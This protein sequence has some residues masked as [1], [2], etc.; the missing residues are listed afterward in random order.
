[1]GKGWGR[2][3][4]EQQKISKSEAMSEKVHCKGSDKAQALNAMRQWTELYKG[5]N[6]LFG[7][8]TVFAL[9]KD[10][11]PVLWWKTWGSKSAVCPELT[12]VAMRVLAHTRWSLLDQ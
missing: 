2:A 7:S 9:A 6:G 10:A 12:T 5:M 4:Y 8:D 3:E 1:M 11:D